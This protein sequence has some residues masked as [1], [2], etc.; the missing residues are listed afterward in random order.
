[1]RCRLTFLDACGGWE[2][3][4]EIPSDRGR[5][6]TIDQ[7]SEE[8]DRVLRDIFSGPYPYSSPKDNLPD[9]TEAVD[10][11]NFQKLQDAYNACLNETA[12]DERGAKPLLALLETVI[13]KY[14]VESACHPLK[15]QTSAAYVSSEGEVHCSESKGSLTSVIEYLQSVGV[16]ALFSLVVTARV[17]DLSI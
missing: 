17:S 4:V 12:I 16:D 7:A 10:V 13:S 8:I 3:R 14:P 5:Y 9:P 1:M 2:K 11:Q 6:G 15:F